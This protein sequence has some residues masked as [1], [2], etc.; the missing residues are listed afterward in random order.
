MTE[1]RVVIA[2]KLRRLLIESSPLIE[3]YTREVCPDCIDVCCRQKHGMHQERDVLYLH[4]LGVEVPRRD[5]ARPLESPCQFMGPRGCNKP[6]W[7]RPFRCTWYF[8]EP[9]L[10]ALNEGPQKK[11][12]QLSAVLQD[13]INLYHMLSSE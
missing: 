1:T 9:L 11:A 5:E 13:I 4:A 6:R 10:A 8:C 3:E 7:I 2:E 12:R